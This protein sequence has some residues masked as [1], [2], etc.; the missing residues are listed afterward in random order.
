MTPHLAEELWQRIGHATLLAQSPW[1]T[2]RA[3]WLV[4]DT[5]TIAVQVNGKRRGEIVLP[6]GRP[7]DEAAAAALTEPNV[8]RAVAGRAP[9]RVIVVPDR[10][11]NVVV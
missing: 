10:L 11:V 5:V 4:A 1:P 2:A 8:Q 3:E 9:R 6:P 7:D